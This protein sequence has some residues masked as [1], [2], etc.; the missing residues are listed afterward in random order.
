MAI[1]DLIPSMDDLSLATLRSNASRIEGGVKGAKQEA[2]ANLLPLI[3][4]EMAD[5]ESKKPPKAAVA[6]KRKVAVA[7]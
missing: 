2:A 6:R 4:A 3:D 1:A 5:R 7:P